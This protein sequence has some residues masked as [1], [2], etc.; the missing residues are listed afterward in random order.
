MLVHASLVRFNTG[1]TTEIAGNFVPVDESVSFFDSMRYMGR[2]FCAHPIALRACL[3]LSG[4]ALSR[5]V[6]ARLRRAKELVGSVEQALRACS[7]LPT[8]SG[9]R[10]RREQALVVA[11]RQALVMQGK[12][13]FTWARIGCNRTCCN[14]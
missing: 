13:K 2:V 1:G 4:F 6:L 11:I 5:W 9:E 8:N 3:I 12:V 7:T 14:Y 10:R